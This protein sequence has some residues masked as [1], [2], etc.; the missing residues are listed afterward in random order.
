[1]CSTLVN[2]EQDFFCFLLLFGDPIAQETPQKWLKM[3]MHWNLFCIWWEIFTFLK[4]WGL[5]YLPVTSGGNLSVPS[6]LQPSRRVTLCFDFVPPRQ[7][8]PLCVMSY[9]F[10]D[11]RRVQFHQYEI[12]PLVGIHQLLWAFASFFSPSVFWDLQWH[13]LLT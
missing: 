8:S 6:A 13:F 9:W 4:Q 3:S 1:V 5:L 7:E 10:G 11:Y 2:E 12:C